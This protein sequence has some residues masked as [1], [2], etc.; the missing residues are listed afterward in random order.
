MPSLLVTNDFPPKVGGIQSYLYELWRRLPPDETTVL[1][2]SYTGTAAWDADESFRIE[3]ARERVLLPGPAIVRRVDAL[4]REVR[5][6]VVFL[7]PMLPIGAIGPFL[8]SGAPYVVIGHGAEV[9]IWGRVPPQ[10]FAARQVL[11][12]AAGVV[13]AGTYPAQEMRRVAGKRLPTLVVPPG[14]D[15]DRFRPA[16][17][18][19]ER[20][21]TRKRFGLDAN[22]PLVLG[23]SRLV[24]RKGFDVLIDAVARLDVDVQ[25]AVGGAGRDR[26]RLERRAR[27]RKISDRVRFL[28]RVDDADLSPLY[29]AADVF[30]MLCR[31]DRWGGLEAEGFGVVFLEAAGCGVPSIAGR[32]GGSHEAVADGETGFV[33]PPRDVDAVRGA[34]TELLE[35]PARRAA[36]GE[37]ARRRAVDAFRYEHIVERLLPLTR[38]DLSVLAPFSP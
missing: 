9:S 4:A 35:D 31:A 22:R 7:D 30:A 11:R 14:V 5:A 25:L 33:V 24:P 2:T 18:D 21:E 6:D 37:A 1:T 15:V 16:M 3:R 34:L 27:E 17:N 28:G 20:A 23:L 29:A 19:A 8:K 10:H 13:A 38:G 32:G 26:E 36:M 12:R